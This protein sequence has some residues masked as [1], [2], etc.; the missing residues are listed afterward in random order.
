MKFFLIYVPF[1]LI[2]YQNIEREK[3]VSGKYVGHFFGKLFKL[4]LKDNGKFVKRVVSIE[5]FDPSSRLPEPPGLDSMLTEVKKNKDRHKT[6]GS[7]V[8]F[9]KDTFEGIVLKTTNQMDSL[10]FLENGNLSPVKPNGYVNTY[11]TTVINGNE[12]IIYNGNRNG[13][14]IGVEYEKN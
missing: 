2:S 10:Y 13:T 4:N 8:Y 14:V 7:W 11:D 6:K 1:F 9:K 3:E 5:S 12:I